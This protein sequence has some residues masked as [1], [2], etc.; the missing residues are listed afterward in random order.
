MWEALE[1]RDQEVPAEAARTKKY[2]ARVD[3]VAEANESEVD[4]KALIFFTL[5]LVNW[6]AA[7]PQLRRMILGEDYSNDRLRHAVA[8]AVRALTKGSPT[9][10]Q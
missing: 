9:N 10:K 1:F 3:A 2:Q 7:A 6:G 5:G 4:P 8:D